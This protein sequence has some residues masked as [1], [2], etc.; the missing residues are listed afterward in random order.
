MYV[1]SFELFV[2]ESLVTNF[3]IKLRLRGNMAANN[4]LFK[5]MKVPELHKFLKE[6]REELGYQ[7]SNWKLWELKYV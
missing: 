2:L 7:V 4:A 1:G 5:N 3:N 6:I